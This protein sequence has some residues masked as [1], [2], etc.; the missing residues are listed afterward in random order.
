MRRLQWRRIVATAGAVLLVTLLTAVVR[1]LQSHGVFATVTPGF[2][3]ACRTVPGP[4]GPA[5][6]VFDDQGKI[7]FVAATDRR[8]RRQPAAQ[9]GIYAYAYAKAGARLE[10]LAG[11]PAD[12]HPTGISLYRGSEGG[13]TL[14]A[15]NRR[16][17]KTN[18]IAIFQVSYQNGMPRLAEVGSIGGGALVS[19][20]AIA[21]VDEDRFYVVNDHAGSSALGRWLDDTLVLPG[22]DIAYFDGIKFTMVANGLNTPGG[23]ALSG[24]GR[25]LY[26]PQAYP[27]TLLTF[28]RNP[29]TGRLSQAG[30]LFI[31]SNLDKAS[32][33]ADGAIWLG[34]HPK[35]FAT[36]RYRNHLT[37]PAPSEI[38]RV[39]V[40]D[41]IPQTADL[42]YANSGAQIGAS[43]VG[44]AADGHLF[45]GSLY[46]AKILDCTL[47]Q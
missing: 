14:M 42:V 18:A 10:K 7:V 40:K 31:P 2:A 46:D 25:Y 36:A 35:A 6:L 27:R 5:D 41:G 20:S 34:S 13:L 30:E 28:E 24:D 32:V 45:I 16:A 8:A 33:A 29:F 12:F 39:G 11:T 1:L 17:D 19:P 9:D 3:G 23:A 44:L 4:A 26:V 21:A 47:P 37:K 22:A 38:F 15:I 43:S